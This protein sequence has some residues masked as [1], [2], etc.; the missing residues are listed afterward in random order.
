[1]VGVDD[2]DVMMVLSEIEIMGDDGAELH[3]LV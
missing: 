3:L 1:M 2:D